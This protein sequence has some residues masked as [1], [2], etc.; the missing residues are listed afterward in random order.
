MNSPD[1]LIKIFGSQSEAA[2]H[3][4]VRRAVVWQWRKN[5]YIPPR[6]APV[7]Q[8]ITGGRITITDIVAESATAKPPRAVTASTR[9]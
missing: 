8:S 4:G 7:I 1:R 9:N 5:G 2:R 3:L 6:W